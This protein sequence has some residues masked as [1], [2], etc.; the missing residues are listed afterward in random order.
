MLLAC[1]E[2]DR[3]R[4][5]RSGVWKERERDRKTLWSTCA[6]CMRQSIDSL[7]PFPGEMFARVCREREKTGFAC[8]WTEK[9][10]KQVSTVCVGRERNRFCCHVKREVL[11]ASSE[12]KLHRYLL[13][14]YFRIPL[15]HN[16]LAHLQ[17][18]SN[19][20]FMLLLIFSQLDLSFFRRQVKLFEVDLDFLKNFATGH[21]LKWYLHR[22]ENITC[23]C[24]RQ[25]WRFENMG[26]FLLKLHRSAKSLDP[27]RLC[28]RTLTCRA[29]EDKS[30][31]RRQVKKIGCNQSFLKRRQ[32]TYL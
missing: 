9:E 1:R 11:P 26:G 31:K 2:R 18:I 28:E 22:R 15:S 25:Q 16:G 6:E 7:P 10:R 8:L 27:N 24:C 5:E 30:T 3:A 13:G 32:L 4:R 17:A 23:C 14:H 21:Q 19:N 12:I 20:Y 29:S